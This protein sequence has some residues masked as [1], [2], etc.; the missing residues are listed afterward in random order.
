VGV[1]D[2]ELGKF[3]EVK[4]F[5]RRPST[6]WANA[7]SHSARN[8]RLDPGPIFTGRGYRPFLIPRYKLEGSIGL[9]PPKKR[10]VS[11]RSINGSAAIGSGVI[12]VCPHARIGMV[13]HYDHG[14]ADCIKILAV[15]R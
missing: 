2:A 6:I 3:G 15:S 9:L 12:A 14:T 8:H 5:H 7:A 11:A 1:C 10:H 4:E 13:M